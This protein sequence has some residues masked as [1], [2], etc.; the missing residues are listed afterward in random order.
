MLPNHE[1][2]LTTRL[3]EKFKF[4]TCFHHLCEL[5]SRED[6]IKLIIECFD[7]TM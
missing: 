1:L 5:R 6:I 7:Y 3:L 4:F 2:A